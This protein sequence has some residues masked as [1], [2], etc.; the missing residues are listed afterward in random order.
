MGYYN[1]Y[2]K[3]ARI[4][5]VDSLEK[6]IERSSGETLT[7]DKIYEMNELANNPENQCYYNSD[8]EACA[9]TDDDVKFFVI[10]T[11]LKK[12]GTDELLYV[13]IIYHN[14]WDMPTGSAVCKT[15]DAIKVSALR[16]GKNSSVRP[17]SDSADNQKNSNK[18]TRSAARNYDDIFCKK[19]REILLFP[20]MRT[21]LDEGLSSYVYAVTQRVLRKLERYDN[22]EISSEELFSIVRLNSKQDKLILNLGLL[23]KYNNDI[24]LMYDL[25]PATDKYGRRRVRYPKIVSSKSDLIEAGFE[26]SDISVYPSRVTFYQSPEEL[27][28]NASI[29]DFDFSDRG[30]LLH[31]IEGRRDRFPQGVSGMS[32]EA[33]AQDMISAIQL[34]VRISKY[35]YT[36]IQPMYDIPRDR[37]VFV[38][39]YFIGGDMHKENELGIIIAEDNGFWTATTLLFAR[40]ADYDARTLSPYRDIKYGALT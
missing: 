11:G 20:D 28:F 38:V 10:N 39:P 7:F 16:E 2:N 26:K 12:W 4:R 5:N 29:E 34:A 33:L 8:F 6:S 25:Y 30:R 37:I 3:L 23:D 32:D 21:T 27:V 14:D 22:G 31:C 1:L 15:L 36:Y 17:T 13:S 40:S 19:L 24:I 9:K 35:D 18:A